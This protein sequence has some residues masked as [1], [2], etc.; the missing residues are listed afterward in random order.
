MGFILDCIGSLLWGICLCLGLGFAPGLLVW[1]GSTTVFMV[2]ALIFPSYLS[3]RT[4]ILLI[5][6]FD[7]GWLLFGGR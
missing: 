5:G 4:V 1:F 7:A 6:A 2:A 3:I